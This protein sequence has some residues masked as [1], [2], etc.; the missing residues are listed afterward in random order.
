MPAYASPNQQGINLQLQLPVDRLHRRGASGR[1]LARVQEGD[2]ARPG[3]TVAAAHG[4]RART[5]GRWEQSR[6]E[7]Q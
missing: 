2:Q 1:Q 6:R 7:E 3:H 4:G 5:W